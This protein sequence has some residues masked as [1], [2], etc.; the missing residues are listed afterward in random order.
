VI[1]DRPVA[2]W[3]HPRHRYQYGAIDARGWDHHWVQVSGP[4]ARRLIEE[5]LMPIAR[6]FYVPVQ[7]PHLLAQ[8]FRELITI[9]E[10]HEPRRH[11][12]AV[13]RLE[14]IVALIVECGTVPVDGRRRHAGIE[15]LAETVREHPETDYA[16][17]TEARRLHLSDSH[18]RRLFRRQIGQAPT[19][20]LLSCR[21]RKAAVALQKAEAQVKSVA[22]ALGY[23]D[24][25]QFSKLFKKKIG[26]APAHYRDAFPR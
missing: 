13:A 12:D 4:R 22:D 8:E 17:E 14:R 26:V 15:A 7:A 16:F 1:L 10:S 21:M 25:A 23:D 3:H 20:F 11:P 18:F 19:E 24:P 6:D 2:F 5:A 9:L